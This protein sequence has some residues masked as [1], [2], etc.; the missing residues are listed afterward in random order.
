MLP[1]SVIE[2]AIDEDIRSWIN[3]KAWKQRAAE[4]ERARKLL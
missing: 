2:Q 1:A 3:A 4:I